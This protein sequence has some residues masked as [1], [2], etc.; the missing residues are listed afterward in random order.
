MIDMTS[1]L[2][3]LTAMM[4]I[5]A[6][7]GCTK[8]SEITNEQVGRVIGYST[9]YKIVQVNDTVIVCLPDVNAAH[10]LQPTVINL[11]AIPQ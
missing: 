7:A 5:G 11:K 2:R 4:L 6:I 10:D 1:I 8:Q 3:V 9:M